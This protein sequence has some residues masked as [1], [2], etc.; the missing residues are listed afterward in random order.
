MRAGTDPRAVKPDG[1]VVGP[2]LRRLLFVVLGLFSL[3][4]V[5][6]VY[7][8]VVT[9]LEWS[10]GRSHQDA[11]YPWMFLLHLVMGLTIA[12]C[13][14]VFA[15]LHARKA[16]HRPRWLAARVGY[17]LL[18]AVVLLIA[19]G[20]L[21][22][23][24]DF[25]E[26]RDPALRSVAYWLHVAIPIGV[27]WLFVLHR[28]AGPRI[29]WK[30]GLSWAGVAACAALAVVAVNAR[31]RAP[32]SRDEPP[33]AQARFTP[34]LA[35][36]VGD[37]LIPAG[38]LMMDEYCAECHADVHSQWEHSAHRFS[39]FNNPAYR[40]SVLETRAVALER[41]G[42]VDASRFCAGCHDPVPLFSGAFD[43][44]DFDD[45]NDPTAMAGITCSSCHA[46]TQINS[47]RG[48]ADY[49][50]GAPAQ[51]PFAYSKSRSLGWINRQ[52]VKAKPAFH[53]RTYLK[54]FHRE[55]EFCGLCHKVHLPE[56]LN[57]YRWLRG[58]NHYDSY[59]LSGVSGHGVASFY[60]PDEAID[61]CSAC[62]MPLTASSDFGAAYFD[63]SRTLEVHDHA[64][65]G[66]NTAIPYLE[67]MPDR[68]IKMHQDFLEGSVRVDIFGLREDGDVGGALT[69]PL[70]PT[71]PALEQGRRY[72]L[73]VVLR[74]LT[75]GHVFTQGTA[76]SNEVWLDVT[77]ASGSRVI[78]RSGSLS[79]DDEVDP[80]SHF[81]NAY[82]LDREGRR[83]DRRNAQD[84]FVPLYDN[85][86]PPGAAD[87]VHYAFEV[88]GDV[89]GEIAIEASLRYRK[90][91]TRFVRHFM[92]DRFTGNDLPITTVATDTVVFPVTEGG[93][94]LARTAAA[95][96]ESA[97]SPQPQWQRWN[98][99]GIGLLR[100]SA[101]GAGRGQLRQAEHAFAV[102]E[103]MGR[104]E[105]ATNLARGYLK[106]GRLDDAAGA[107]KRAA[108]HDPP[109]TP[110]TVGW[111]SA[112]VYKERGEL[113][114][115]ADVYRALA[116]TAFSDARRRGF[117]FALD[118]RLLNELG[119]TLIERARQ[120]RGEDL[121][122][123]REALLR[124][125]LGWFERVLEIDPENVSAHYN[126]ALIHEELGDPERTATHRSLHARYK[127]DD[128]ARDR[129]VAIHRRD[130]PAANHAA[131]AVVIYDL[132]RDTATI[133]P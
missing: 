72:L 119:Q 128:N 11:L 124:E 4:A 28:L 99:Y 120:V 61:T 34:S 59:L 68:V 3:L 110:W 65:R 92:G 87:T 27:A 113:E 36:T 62:H 116:R 74:T 2:R 53:K 30:V 60:Y 43:A 55:A 48:N 15:T 8:A 130:N 126:L 56:E 49:T 33:S 90:F 38:A 63:G 80:W 7:L 12:P 100:K 131:E 96:G 107:L 41:D 101:R 106:E 85:Q 42:N 86:I 102:V 84:I 70:R 19:S 18:T 83:I 103:E 66:A 133:H 111:L 54:P 73:E 109:A 67:G 121:R 79:R 50:I 31:Q 88:P 95:T 52:L 44:T 76:D 21:L 9:A 132:Q 89:T 64:F 117:D 17:A 82:V 10:T 127:P 6:S 14:L 1:P 22:T 35:R 118:Y 45:V 46:I 105:G 5:N 71:V 39:S 23:R 40:F 93:A 108:E 24:F 32:V 81:V 98:D 125:A 77:V 75:L 91:D 123:R 129:A 16:R 122:P 57:N 112:R 78:G 114:E 115:A 58:Q 26:V 97:P 51:Y 69:A 29:R 94:R 25:F 20:L 37:Q 47:P 104:A 13:A